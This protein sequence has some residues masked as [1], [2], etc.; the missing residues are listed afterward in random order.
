MHDTR[1]YGQHLLLDCYG[2]NREKLGD[3]GALFTFLDELPARIGMQK[4]GPPQM[5]HFPETAENAGVTGIVMIVTSHI[6]IHTY[7]HQGCFFMDIFSCKDFDTAHITAY[8]TEFFGVQHVEAQE[9]TRG[10]YFSN[11]QYA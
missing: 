5:A 2:A 10:K 11:A 8:I 7:T 6:S 3:V 4:I 1:P 9:I